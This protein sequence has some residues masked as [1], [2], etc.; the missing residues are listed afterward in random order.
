MKPRHEATPGT[1]ATRHRYATALSLTT[2]ANRL[3][4]KHPT[5]PMHARGRGVA[6]PLTQTRA[7]L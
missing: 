2:H 4:L 1:R 3:A 6:G 5:P 7:A